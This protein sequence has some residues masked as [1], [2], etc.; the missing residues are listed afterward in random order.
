MQ[1]EESHK[2]NDVVLKIVLYKEGFVKLT[3]S[4]KVV[5][6]K[7]KNPLALLWPFLSAIGLM[8]GSKLIFEQELAK[9]SKAN[10]IAELKKLFQME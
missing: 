1:P 5:L 7:P 10:D 4:G 8:I 9:L 2:P 3:F 6:L